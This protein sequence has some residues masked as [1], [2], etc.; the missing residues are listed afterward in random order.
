MYSPGRA[1]YLLLIKFEGN[2]SGVG[3]VL[4]PPPRMGPGLLEG[5]PLRLEISGY[6][7]FPDE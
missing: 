7:P 5:Q 6:C 4:L 1:E 2:P 3:L